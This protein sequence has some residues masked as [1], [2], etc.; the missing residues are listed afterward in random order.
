MTIQRRQ[1]TMQKPPAV[2]LRLII[3]NVALWI[4]FA[5]LVNSFGSREAADV[6]KTLWLKADT[7]VFGLYLWQLGTYAFLH[8]LQ[9]ISHILFN[10]MALY[11]LGTPL[12]ARWGGRPFLKFYLLSALGA[13]VFS[14]LVGLLAPSLFGN[15]VVGASGA[16]FALLTAFSMLF[17]TAE[18]LLFFILPVKARHV[19]WIAVAIDIVLFATMPRYDVAIHTHM[20]G[21]L[22]GWL[23]VTGNWHPGRAWRRFRRWQERR[24]G[25]RGGHGGGGGRG[26]LVVLDGGRDR[27]LN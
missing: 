21:A 16:I 18:I 7:T 8:D 14:A 22:T 6:Y 24:G 1:L 15:P 12:A 13:G 11:F 9:G 20:G 23:L 17:P 25:G 4:V 2:V 27:Y 3:V 19:I 10:A 5:L 26:R